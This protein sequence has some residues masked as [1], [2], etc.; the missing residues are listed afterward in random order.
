MTTVV[1]QA[2]SKVAKAAQNVPPYKGTHVTEA[3]LEP[4]MRSWQEHLQRISPF[5]IT[6]KGVW[7]DKTSHGYLFF[8]GDNDSS[9]HIEGPKLLHFRSARLEDV[10][11]RRKASWKSVLNAK[12]EL[13]TPRVQLYDEDGCPNTLLTYSDQPSN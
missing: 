1:E 4:R 12:M 7:W 8:D 2:E 6:G 3:F 9:S 11:K 5:L 10:V 13:P